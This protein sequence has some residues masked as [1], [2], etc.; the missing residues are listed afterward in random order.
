MKLS[1]SQLDSVIE[2]F[3]ENGVVCPCC[4][5]SG[6]TVNYYSVDLVQVSNKDG[7]KDFDKNQ[8]CMP[9]LPVVCKSCSHIFLFSLFGL[10]IIDESSMVNES[11]N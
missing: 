3:E 2:K 1:D 4:G 6:I 10:G 8:F 7:V 9:A 5:D 11:H